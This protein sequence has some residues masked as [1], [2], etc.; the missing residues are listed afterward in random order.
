MNSPLLSIIIPVYN[1]GPYIKKCLDS[2]LAQTFQ[3]FEVILIDDGST[4]D[5]GKICDQYTALD[6]R[7]KVIHKPNGGVSSARNA[8]L[9]ICAGKYIAM[10]DPDDSLAPD[11]YEN[12]NDLETHPDID[13]LQFPYFNCYPDGKTEKLEVPS[14]LIQGKDQ[15]L[16]NWWSGSILHFSNLNKIFRRSV[17]EG[18]RY[19]TG[20]L[21]EDTYLIAD[22]VEKCN[23]VFISEKGGYFVLI[24]NNSQ[25]SSYDFSKHIDLFEAHLHN[26]AKI[27]EY[28]LLK[29]VRV[30]AFSRLFRRLIS[31]HLS[32]PEADVRPYLKQVNNYVPRWQDIFTGNNKSLF[33]WIV[34]LKILGVNVFFRLFSWYLTKKMH[35]LPSPQT[36]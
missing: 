28:S 31:A 36:K 6:S 29:P 23:T 24:R 3:N 14:R 9:D 2:V 7:F 10:L 17:F 26:Y 8:G 16:L 20:H 18:L 32:A 13:I 15:I 12:V 21:S 5:S 27:N 19:R 35:G 22:F 1:V 30:E 34:T 33:P 11:S 4:D 25:S